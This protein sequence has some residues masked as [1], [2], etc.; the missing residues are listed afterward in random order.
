M[1][2]RIENL[3]NNIMGLKEIKLTKTKQEILENRLDEWALR[4][5]LF[6]SIQI[7]IDISC[8]LAS[9]YNLG[10]VKSYKECIE[11]LCEFEYID[12]PLCEHLVQMAGL[13]N[14]LIH[15]Y[16]GI[17]KEK[18][19]SFLDMVDDMAKFIEKVS[20]YI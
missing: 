19:Y 2:E 14:I 1:L 11:K 13:R 17:D 12:K 3:E 8:H 10:S 20:E 9:K 18:L 5:G 6:E 7:I 16:V 15:E 4:Y